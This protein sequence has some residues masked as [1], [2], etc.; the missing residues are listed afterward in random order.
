MPDTVPK[1]VLVTG[2]SSGIGRAAAACFLA[3]GWAVAATMR[4][5][6]SVDLGES[7]RLFRARLDVTEPATIEAAVSAAVSRFGRLDAVVNNAGYGLAGPLEGASDEQ[8]RRQVEVNLIGLIAVTRACLPHLRASRGVVVNVSSI[9]GRAASPLMSCYQATKFAVEGLSESLRFELRSHGV[10]VKV[11]EP[12]GI[13]TDF[14]GRSLAWAEHPEYADQVERY[15][16]FLE[17]VGARLPG[18]EPVARVIERAAASR[19]G[20]LRYAGKPGPYLLLHR[21]LPDAAW[22][23]LLGLMIQPMRK[24]RVEDGVRARSVSIR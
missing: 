15:R 14:G 20:R 12:G 11:V 2:A 17:K 10:R 9:G 4:R 16:A 7:P 13:R 19:S 1:V 24:R 5:P 21:V 3:R 23:G 8:V 22:R 6:E 18:P